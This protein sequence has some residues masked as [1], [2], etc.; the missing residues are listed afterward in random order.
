MHRDVLVDSRTH[1]HVEDDHLDGIEWD[2]AAHNLHCGRMYQE[3]CR[4][5]TTKP[6]DFGEYNE[7]RMS[8]Y[9][10]LSM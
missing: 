7:M 8:I 1:R 9:R 6:L 2:I 3:G 5:S 10:W 4:Q